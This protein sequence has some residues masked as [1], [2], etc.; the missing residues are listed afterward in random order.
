MIHA[1]W[2]IYVASSW[3]NPYQP[4][5]VAALQSA[6]CDPGFD[7]YDFRDVNAGFHWRDIDPLWESWTLAQYRAAL[8][9]D[10]AI[11]GF[12]NDKEHIDACDGL[13][14]VLTRGRVNAR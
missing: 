13:V 2:N 7:P 9:N 1:P 14:V 12:N 4:D 10:R 3:R 6:D 8:E 11:H 5:V